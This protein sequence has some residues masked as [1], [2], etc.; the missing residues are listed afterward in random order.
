MYPRISNIAA[1]T[2]PD[3]SPALLKGCLVGLSRDR[4]SRVCS[5]HPRVSRHA[6]VSTGPR[7]ACQQQHDS[8]TCQFRCQPNSLEQTLNNVSTLF[9]CF[10]SRLRYDHRCADRLV[11]RSWGKIAVRSECHQQLRSTGSCNFIKISSEAQPCLSSSITCVK[12]ISCLNRDQ[13]S[14]I[15]L[16]FP[17]CLIFWQLRNGSNFLDNIQKLSRRPFPQLLE[18]T[19]YLLAVVT[20]RGLRPILSTGRR[21]EIVA[22]RLR[23][24]GVSGVAARCPGRHSLRGRLSSTRAVNRQGQS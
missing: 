20:S 21:S 19:F 1:E 16:L 18:R 24:C 23:P 10:M 2:L 14:H 8:I 3:L 6:R 4:L 9:P 5:P 22:L 13:Y 17:L 15:A 11:G 12:P 7:F